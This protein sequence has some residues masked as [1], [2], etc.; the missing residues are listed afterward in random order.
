LITGKKPELALGEEIQALRIQSLTRQAIQELRTPERAVTARDFEQLAGAVEHVKRAH[1][2]PRRDLTGKDREIRRAVKPADVSVVILPKAGEDPITKVTA[3]LDGARLLT[4]QVHV[5]KAELVSIALKLTV[6]DKQGIE[7][8][9]DTDPT[10]APVQITLMLYAQPG[11]MGDSLLRDCENALFLWFDNDKGGPDGK[12]WPLGRTIYTSEI[13]HVL[14]RVQGVSHI[15]EVRG[16]PELAV[17][18]ADEWR[19]VKD[20]RAKQP[21]GIGLDPFELPRPERSEKPLKVNRWDGSRDM[22]P[23]GAP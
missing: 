18:A 15:E 4:T 20:D 16:S 8:S 2:V 9:R 3:K 21:V 22:F 5:I 14:A 12:G 11:F 6:L 13:Y 1:C 17:I 23:G 10:A 7:W 19:I